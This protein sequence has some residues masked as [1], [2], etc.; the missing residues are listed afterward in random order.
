METIKRPAGQTIILHG[1][2]WQTYESL[3]ADQ[4]DRSTP[5]FAYDRGELEILSPSP[6]HEK[7]N[8]R[9][10]QLALAV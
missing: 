9:I 3:L 2:G 1:V 8:R 10:A 7:L 6:E 4:K 5:R